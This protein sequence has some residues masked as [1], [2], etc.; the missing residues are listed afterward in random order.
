MGGADGCQRGGWRWP[1]NRLVG[2]CRLGECYN[3]A[4]ISDW[5]HI[6]VAGLTGCDYWQGP[7]ITDVKLVDAVCYGT[8][9]T[10]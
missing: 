4:V 7:A 3:W 2:A 10:A 6:D 9:L 1:D 8:A 5:V